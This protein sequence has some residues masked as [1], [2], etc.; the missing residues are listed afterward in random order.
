M[1]WQERVA[2]E[3][4]TAGQG[5]PFAVLLTPGQAAHYEP[6]E[7]LLDKLPTRASSLATM[8]LRLTYVDL[9]LLDAPNF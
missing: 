2:T 5:R 6:A 4:V 3:G 7:Q 8:R 1:R 9:A